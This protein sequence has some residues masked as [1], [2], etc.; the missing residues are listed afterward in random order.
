MATR[1]LLG[2]CLASM[3]LVWAGRGALPALAQVDASGAAGGPPTVKQA[4][5]FST[6]AGVNDMLLPAVPPS[7][8][9]A[10]HAAPVSDTAS[11]AEPTQRT[12]ADRLRAWDEATRRNAQLQVE[13]P[14]AAAA[15]RGLAYDIEAAWTAGAYDAALAQLEWLESTGAPVAVGVSWLNPLP[16][17]TLR[18]F[19]DVRIGTRSISASAA[20]D[21]D[22]ASKKLF[23]VIRWDNANGWGAYMS[24]DAGQTWTETYFWN[25]GA[26]QHA[27]S[28]D[29]TVVSG[30]VYVG[31]VTSD[32]PAE[33]RMRRLLV[34]TGAADSVYSYQVAVN[35]GTSTFTEAKVASNADS[36]SNRV[37][38]AARQSDNTLRFVWDVSTD[39][40]T[41]SEQSPAGVPACL[42][43][44]DVCWNPG[45]ALYYAYISYIGTD[46]KVYVLRTSGSTWSVATSTTFDGTHLRSAISAWADHVICAHELQMTNGQGIRY[47]ISHDGG[48]VWDYYNYVAEP[49]AGEGPYQM[50]DVT[51]RGGAGTAVVFSQETGEP[52]E[53]LIRY[54]R[55]YAPGVWHDAILIND[56][57][58]STGTWNVLSWVPRATTSTNELSY[59]MIYTDGLASY[60]SHLGRL[61]GDLNC[62]DVVGFGDINPF[63]LA[64]TN[65]AGYA[66]LYPDCDAMNG[67]INAD[68][69][70]N[71]GDIN[72]FVTLLT[73]GS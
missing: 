4:A 50:A 64:L 73:S 53:V 30:Y 6:S 48:G 13:L 12:L 1:R 33:G 69:V 70:L 18:S 61:P 25:A 58:V 8:G 60:Y 40:A 29:M 14:A 63:V 3:V 7:A 62:D 68:N 46:N 26:G 28:V 11:P 31:Y 44:L 59:G 41:F 32:F 66:T 43:G 45:Y 47:F 38:F 21:Y 36:Y 27:L 5:A 49:A 10:R 71:F 55:N 17:A 51:A 37:Y 54:R 9:A 22:A 15:Q 20:L 39:G 56:H 34:S 67:D 65:A 19:N 35:A 72:P 52:D 16:G 42:G 57:D 24:T 2:A 23:A